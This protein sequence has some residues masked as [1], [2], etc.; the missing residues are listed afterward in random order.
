MLRLQILI[1]TYRNLSCYDLI[2]PYD[3]ILSDF[4]SKKLDKQLK[5]S[6]LSVSSSV[7]GRED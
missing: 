3:V 2:F 1:L 4:L 7:S 6:G 5:P